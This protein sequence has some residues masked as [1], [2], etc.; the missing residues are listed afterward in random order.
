MRAAGEDVGL[1]GVESHAIDKIAAHKHRI[2]TKLSQKSFSSKGW[3]VPVPP[4]G[5][6]L[7]S[8]HRVPNLDSFIIGA[9][10]KQSALLV[11]GYGSH[12]IRVPPQGAQVRPIS[13]YRMPS[14]V[15]WC[16]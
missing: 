15:I 2:R 13:V 3:D 10:G 6:L 11:E 14:L 1:L 12:P 4:Q 5:A 9:A 7:F 16:F 8:T